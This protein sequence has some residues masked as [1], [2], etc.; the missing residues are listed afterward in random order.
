MDCKE[1]LPQIHEYLDGDL[2]GIEAARLKEHLVSCPDCNKR[3]RTLEKTDALVRSMPRSHAPEGLEE[4]IMRA[5]PQPAKRLAWLH[6]MKR[7]PAV[8]VASVFLLVMMSSFLS[9]W[10]QD[11]DLTVKSASLDQL[12]FQG[13]TV[14]VPAGHTVDGNLTV[15]NGNIQVDGEVKGNLV[16][17]DGSYNLASTAKISGQIKEIDR[18]LDWLWFKVNEVVAVGAK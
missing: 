13:D 5:L 9:M 17:I 7:H 4:A 16:V 1:A 6:W 18:A 2:G 12:V 10:N 15:T 14:V 11:K 8:S 3:F